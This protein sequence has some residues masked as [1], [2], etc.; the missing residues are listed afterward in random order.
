VV[1]AQISALIFKEIMQRQKGYLYLRP[2]EDR[3]YVGSKDRLAAELS[4]LKGSASIKDLIVR[5]HR[6]RRPRIG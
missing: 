3:S 4:K 2:E 6:D 5:L 1:K